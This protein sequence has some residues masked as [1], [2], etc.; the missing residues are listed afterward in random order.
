MT[1][2]DDRGSPGGHVPDPAA[3]AGGAPGRA[4]VAAGG[5]G[6]GGTAAT[7]RWRERFTAPGIGG[8]TWP[9]HD[10]TRLAVVSS[11]GG[12]RGAWAYDLASGTRRRVSRPDA[13]AEEAIALPDGTGAVWWLDP[14]GDERGRWMVSPF[15]DGDDRPLFPGIADAWAWGLSLVPGRAAAD[16]NRGV[17]RK[18]RPSADV[19]SALRHSRAGSVRPHRAV[20]SRRP[21]T[22]C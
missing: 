7:S 12:I 4:E 20:R 11:E 19:K 2:A 5:A 3:G 14:S 1:G 18:K 15:D 17:P 10:G 6:T 16:A 22:R 8:V 9:A 13:G 21:C